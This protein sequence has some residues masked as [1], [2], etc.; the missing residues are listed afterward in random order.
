MVRSLT[1]NVRVTLTPRMPAVRQLRSWTG[2]ARGHDGFE[3]SERFGADQ[4]QEEIDQK[5]H[6]HD[7]DEYVFH[8]SEPP[9]CVG[10]RNA[11]NEKANRHCHKDQILHR[12]PSRNDSHV[13]ITPFNIKMPSIF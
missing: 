5:A 10:V 12:S 3:G 9:A 4:G 7:S 8:D 11:D 1:L 2:L 13:I 6:R